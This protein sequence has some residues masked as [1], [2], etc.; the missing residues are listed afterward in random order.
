[1][2]SY[3]IK[4]DGVEKEVDVEESRTCPIH[5]F[6]VPSRFQS[7]FTTVTSTTFTNFFG[8]VKVFRRDPSSALSFFAENTKVDVA[9]LKIFL[10]DFIDLSFNDCMGED[11]Q[12][13]SC[14]VALWTWK[15]Q[16]NGFGTPAWHRDGPLHPLKVDT[17]PFTRS[18]YAVTLLGQPT[19]FLVNT[20]HVIEV[21][22][23]AYDNDLRYDDMASL[24]TNEGF[25]TAELEK[26]E[27][28]QIVR[29]TW[30]QPD[31]IVHAEPVI[32]EDR[33]FLSVIFGNDGEIR[34]L[35]DWRDEAYIET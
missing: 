5:I 9:A 13:S 32:T 34:G 1:M 22:S 7:P 21:T 4:S 28:G 14:H 35:A 10:E 23:K 31:S 24:F 16:L 25:D 30:G 8:S 15:N 3:I 33:V 26:V 19:R 18:K 6:P 27:L 2:S 11:S 12:K 17:F 29:F 20:Q